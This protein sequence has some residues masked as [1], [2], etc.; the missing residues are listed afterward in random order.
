M[1]LSSSSPAPVRSQR[2]WPLRRIS[3]ISW[4]FPHNDSNNAE[5]VHVIP[6]SPEEEESTKLL[7]GP[8][9][10][11]FRIDFGFVVLSVMTI[12]HMSV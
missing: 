1:G 12:L 7:Q 3:H 4:L 6:D 11:E 2:F 5:H 9:R 10:L 8:P